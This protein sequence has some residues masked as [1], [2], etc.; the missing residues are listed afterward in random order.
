MSSLPGHSGAHCREMCQSHLLC[1]LVFIHS[2]LLLFSGPL[3]SPPPAFSFP[4][5]GNSN[6]QLAWGLQWPAW[7]PSPGRGESNIDKRA[8]K[9][10]TEGSCW[11][12]WREMTCRWCSG[13]G[14]KSLGLISAEEKYEARTRCWRGWRTDSETSWHAGFLL[15]I[16]NT[17]AK[18]I[19]LAR[20]D[21][22]CFRPELKAIFLSGWPRPELPL[23][24]SPYLET[25]TAA[26]FLC[27]SPL[28]MD[29]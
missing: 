7:L 8:E 22:G 26:C 13:Q 28:H 12:L 14:W 2:F 17:S 15:R 9:K 6:D 4:T 18:Q 5:T 16:L 3:Q 19:Q 10:G 29:W 11:R 21:K 23:F 24:L 27:S 1:L 25:K 20:K